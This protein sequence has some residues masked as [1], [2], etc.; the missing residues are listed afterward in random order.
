VGVSGPRRVFEHL[1]FGGRSFC[2]AAK[3]L[4]LVVVDDPEVCVILLG[5]LPH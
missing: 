1:E 3:I 4:G 5:Q 2:G